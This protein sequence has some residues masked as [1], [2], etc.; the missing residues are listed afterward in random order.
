MEEKECTKCKKTLPISNFGYRYDL[1]KH[2]NICKDCTNSSRGNHLAKR[3]EKLMLS[4]NGKKRCHA[5]KEILDL[6]CF[7]KSSSSNDGRYYLCLK[8]RSKRRRFTNES[9][10]IYRSKLRVKYN[11]TD[12]QITRHELMTNCEICGIEFNDFDPNK[13]DYKCFDHCHNSNTYRGTLCKMCNLALGYAKDN[14][15]I[16]KN[17][18]IYLDNHKIVKGKVV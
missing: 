18:I 5:C 1:N 16:L 4:E 10:T 15:N 17:M 6:S 8:C 12:E 13:M 3:K 7:N 11:A 9:K 14:I 2:R